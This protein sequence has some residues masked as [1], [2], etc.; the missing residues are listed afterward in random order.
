[1]EKPDRRRYLQQLRQAAVGSADLTND[2]SWDMFLSYL[3]AALEDMEKIKGAHIGALMSP[4]LVGLDDIMRTKIA[5]ASIS[6]QIA[7]L[8]A[9]IS[10]PKDIIASGEVAA[11][12]M[13]RIPEKT[14]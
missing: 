6:D 1:M 5:V 4:D 8:K 10:L 2:P 12:L 3:Q 14:D 13:D 7:L 9:V 11:S